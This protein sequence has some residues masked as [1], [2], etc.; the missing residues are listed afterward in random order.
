MYYCKDWTIAIE[1]PTT[2]MWSSYNWS[3][4]QSKL[5]KEFSWKNILREI[6]Q[7]NQKGDQK[8]PVAKALRELW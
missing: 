1:P 4:L 2:K 7:G 6:C 5:S 3:F 8:E